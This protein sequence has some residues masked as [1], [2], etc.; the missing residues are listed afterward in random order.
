MNLIVHDALGIDEIQSIIKKVKIIVSYFKKIN[1]AVQTLLKYQE[2]NGVKEPKRL[3][4]DVATRWNSTFF[5]LERVVLLEM[6]LRHSLAVTNSEHEPLTAYEWTV[7]RELCELLEPCAEVTT[8]MSGESYIT[9]SKVIPITRGLASSIKRISNSSDDGVVKPVA[10]KILTGIDTRF[11]DLEKRRTFA[12]CTFLDPKFKHH[13]FEN[14]DTIETTK[15]M[16]IEQVNALIINQKPAN[17]HQEEE[18]RNQLE[19]ST[20]NH[21]PQK[22]RK[23]SI[24]DDYQ[25]TINKV[26]PTTGNTY[27]LAVLEVQR[28]MDDIPLDHK[29]NSLEWWKSHVHVYPNLAVLVR[30][31]CNFVATSVP[32]KRVC[33][34]TGNI[35][36]QRRTRLTTSKVKQMIFLKMN[37]L[38]FCGHFPMTL[39]CSCFCKHIIFFRPYYLCM[40]PCRPC[41]KY[42][43]TFLLSTGFNLCIYFFILTQ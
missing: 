43:S 22:K 14:R 2:Q 20:D 6:A 1:V 7:C 39:I 26:K 18:I 28:Y 24:W 5:M 13:M 23:V 31:K 37:W 19:V 40:I 3:L 36:A 33:S 17:Q 30:E 11:P 38:L 42:I 25:Q 32:C 9:A 29:V 21:Q 16:A 27:S 4:Q 12:L 8:E 41:V 15:R 10:K 34:K 35:L